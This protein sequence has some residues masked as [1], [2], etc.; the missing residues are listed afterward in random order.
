[1]WR[2]EDLD[3]YNTEYD[4]ILVRSTDKYTLP[5]IVVFLLLT[6]HV[7]SGLVAGMSK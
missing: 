7:V 1:M 3:E 6:R 5:L 2:T 4:T